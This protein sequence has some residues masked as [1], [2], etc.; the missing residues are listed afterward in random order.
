M[1]CSIFL[2]Q[3]FSSQEERGSEATTGFLNISC[4]SS[5]PTFPR[6]E[7]HL[8]KYVPS[9]SLLTLNS[10][11]HPQTS[12]LVWARLFLKPGRVGR[13]TKEWVFFLTPHPLGFQELRVSLSHLWSK[14]PSPALPGPSPDILGSAFPWILGGA[15]VHVLSLCV[16]VTGLCLCISGYVCV[17]RA[18]VFWCLFVSFLVFTDQCSQMGGRRT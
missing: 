10:L 17:S 7:A 16:Y 11:C 14:T 13:G 3:S 4:G 9:Y 8:A 5:D 12:L 6:L 2:G 18:C 15:G 1:L